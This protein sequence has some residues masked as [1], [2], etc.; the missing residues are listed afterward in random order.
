MSIIAL[1]T[2]YRVQL[3][4][5]DSLPAPTEGQAARRD[6]LRCKLAW[7]ERQSPSA[8]RHAAP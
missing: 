4:H 5:Y 7:A 3:A 1:A 6:Q 8:P 2:R